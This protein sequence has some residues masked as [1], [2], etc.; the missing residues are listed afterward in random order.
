M[1]P[2][3]LILYAMCPRLRVA[4]V[5]TYALMCRLPY[6]RWRRADTGLPRNGSRANWPDYLRRCCH[7]RGKFDATT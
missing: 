6:C 5:V 3:H 1:C 7:A 4:N 2:C